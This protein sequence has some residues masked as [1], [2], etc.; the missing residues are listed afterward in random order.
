MKTVVAYFA[1]AVVFVSVPV[2]AFGQTL[3]GAFNPDDATHRF[4][5]YGGWVSNEGTTKYSWNSS[6]LCGV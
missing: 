2:L 4:N 1:A 3:F 6:A 5:L